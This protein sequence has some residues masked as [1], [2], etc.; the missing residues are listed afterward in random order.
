MRE[1]V[2]SELN[3]TWNVERDGFTAT[4]PYPYEP[5]KF[6]NLIFS[7]KDR[8]AASSYI[9]LAAHIDSKITPDGFKAATDSAVPVAII[10]YL[11]LMLES[12][13]AQSDRDVK[14][15]L[16]DGEEAFV[17]WSSEDSLYGSRHL[18]ESM[19]NNQSYVLNHIYS[20]LFP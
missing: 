16:F 1:F 2:I 10:I 6:E 17:R 8:D 12:E 3:D 19:A 18:S 7:R 4:P 11:M 15:F 14:I 9:V 5:V 20:S 13:L